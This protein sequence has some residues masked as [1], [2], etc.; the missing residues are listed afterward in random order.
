MQ[1]IV[2][3]MPMYMHKTTIGG[4]GGS[5]ITCYLIIPNYAAYVSSSSQ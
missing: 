4:W 2:V 5:S 3:H 1:C